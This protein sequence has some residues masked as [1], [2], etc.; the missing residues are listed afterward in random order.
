[1]QKVRCLWS[2]LYL[3]FC[4]L[5]STNIL[6][7]FSLFESC[8]QLENSQLSLWHVGVYQKTDGLQLS[9]PFD[10]QNCLENRQKRE[11]PQQT[12][13]F[14]SHCHK[15]IFCLCIILDT[16]MINHVAWSIIDGSKMIHTDIFIGIYSDE[17]KNEPKNRNPIGDRF[18]KLQNNQIWVNATGLDVTKTLAAVIYIGHELC[19]LGSSITKK[20]KTLNRLKKR[21]WTRIVPM[22]HHRIQPCKHQ[23]RSLPFVYGLCHNWDWF[24]RSF[25]AH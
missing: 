18:S 14:F 4:S 1:M 25:R 3:S 13:Y 23:I 8:S 20:R 15:I 24:C 22:A 7:P 12:H 16:Y 17:V 5:Q 11:L 2:V 9:F 10:F 6:L 19:H 21:A